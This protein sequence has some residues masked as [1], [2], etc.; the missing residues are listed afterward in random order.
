MALVLELNVLKLKDFG[1][2]AHMQ[3]GMLIS[4]KRLYNGCGT[5]LEQQ[6]GT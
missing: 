6:Q 4:S 2:R 1:S 5:A 3:R